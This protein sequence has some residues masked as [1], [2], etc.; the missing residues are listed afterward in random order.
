MKAECINGHPMVDGNVQWKHNPRNGK[1][2]P[3]CGE[4]RRACQKARRNNLGPT[5]ARHATKWLWEDNAYEY[6]F[7]RRELGMTPDDIAV[8]VGLSRGAMEQALRRKIGRKDQ[9]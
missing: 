9:W 1:D 5:L 6:W 2:Y 3:Y 4:C 7:M 8:K